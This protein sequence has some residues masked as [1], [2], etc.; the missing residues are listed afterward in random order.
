MMPGLFR[1]PLFWLATGAVAAAALIAVG[2]R[3]N[4]YTSSDAYCMSCHRHTEADS[5]WKLSPHYD[6]PSGVRVSCVECHLP[7]QG[8]GKLRAKARMGAKDLWAHWTKDSAEINWA[9]KRK[10]EAARELVFQESCWDC[11]QTVFPKD[12]SQEGEEAHLYYR[13]KEEEG[14]EGLHCINCHLNTGHYMEGWTHGA[15]TGFGQV[16]SA[17]AEIFTAPARV[18]SFATFVETIPGSSV[19]MTMCAIP[20]GRFTMGSP[21]GEGLRQAHEGPAVEVELS[22]FFMAEVE[23]TWDA[24][25]AFYAQ[26]A[27]E[28]RSTDTEG[29]RTQAASGT[30]LTL[31]A[32]SGATP[33]YGQPD[34]GWGMGQRPAISISYH[35]AETFCQWLSVVTGKTYRLPTEA[36]WEYACRAGSQDPYFFA[37]DPK[38]LQAKGRRQREALE[39]CNTY[40]ISAANSRAST[41]EPE[42]VEANAWGLKN[43]LGNVAEFCSD[44]YSPTTYQDYADLGME[45]L[46]NPTGPESGRE[47]V[48][49]GGTFMDAPATLRSAFRD[50]TQTAHWLRTDPQMPKSIWWYSDCFHVGFR[51]VCEYNAQTGKPAATD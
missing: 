29:L 7:P 42:A 44:W 19:S 24:Y 3:V 45:P 6:N 39:L 32:I 49:R 18:D 15:N 26:T 11:H 31:D 20:G 40:V 17:A 27:A 12:L 35:A 33:P 51:V 22:P 37:A 36:E 28:G 38:Q 21:Q 8:M 5:L 47:H 25:Q 30:P 43:M 9:E 2:A 1:K 46:L 14:L 41:H 34:Q 48:I 10:P 13:M 50:S 4:Q 16:S 23:T